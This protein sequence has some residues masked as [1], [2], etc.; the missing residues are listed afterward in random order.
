MYNIFLLFLFLIGTRESGH[1][2]ADSCS[3]DSITQDVICECFEGYSGPRCEVCAENYFGS[4]EGVLSNGCE[5][6]NCNNNTDLHRAGNCDRQTGHCLQCLFNT[7][8]R[9]CEVCKPG[10]YGDALRQDC[11]D[12][13]CNVLGTDKNA[14]PCDHHT[15]QCPCLPHVIGQLCDSCEEYHWR[16]ASGQGCDPCE[17]DAVGS[18]SDRFSCESF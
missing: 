8:G 9:N 15:G 13:R 11:R 4:P 1:S 2:Y 7:A 12:C 3:L 18:V 14:G 10:F 6:C 16:I 5:M 17:C